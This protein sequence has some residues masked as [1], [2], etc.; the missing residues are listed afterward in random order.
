MKKQL[1]FLLVALLSSVTTLWAQ[2]ETAYSPVL[3]VNFR[4]GAGNT[5]WNS[6]FPNDAAVEGNN[7]FELTSTA[8]FFSLQKYTVPNLQNAT[9]LVLTLTVGS[10]S[11]VDAVRLWSYSD[12]AWTAET[13]VDDI[14]PKVQEILGVDLRSTEGTPNEPLVKGAKVADS[15]PAKATWTIQGTA[16]TTIKENAASDGTFTIMLTNDNLTS[17]S[18]KRSYLSNNSVNDEANR[19]C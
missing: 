11:G 15:S 18:N 10:K 19:P 17:S 16:L 3:D 6:G 14:Y 4:T 1:L 7:D 13:G 2:T 8:G 12:N 5:A 9:K